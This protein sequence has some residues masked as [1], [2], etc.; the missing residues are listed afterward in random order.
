ML[1]QNVPNEQQYTQKKSTLTERTD[2][3][4]FSQR[5]SILTTQE[6]PWGSKTCEALVKSPPSTNQHSVFTGQMPFLLPAHK[7]KTTEALMA[8]L[9]TDRRT[10]SP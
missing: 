5:R 8:Y 6:P 7:K 1:T 4:W 9:V 10:M 3:A 2:R